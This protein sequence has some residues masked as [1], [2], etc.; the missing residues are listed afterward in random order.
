MCDQPGHITKTCLAGDQ[1]ATLDIREMLSE[2]QAF[3]YVL[4]NVS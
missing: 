3:P 2:Q 1:V 4:V